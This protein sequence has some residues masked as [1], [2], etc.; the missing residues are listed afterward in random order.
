MDKKSVTI[1][2]QSGD[3]DKALCAFIFAN[4]Y[5]SL[6]ID[7][8]MWFMIWGYN[9]L[10]RRRSLFSLLGRKT[11]PVREGAYRVLET[12]N[13]LQPMIELLNRGGVHHLPLSRLN[14]MGLGPFLFDKMLKKKSIMGLEE[15]IRS[16]DELGVAFKMC[17]ICFDAMGISVDDLIVPNVEV[18][19]VAEYAKDTMEAHVNL[20]I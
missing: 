4:G 19:G 15:L 12:D 6:G 14:L 8:K 2:L 13:I 9:C 18:K 11:D 5:A 10:K 20:F 7:V 1:L 17:Q 16:A 3:L